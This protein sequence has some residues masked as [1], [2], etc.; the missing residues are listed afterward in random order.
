MRTRLMRTSLL[1]PILLALLFVA[2]GSAFGQ[3]NPDAVYQIRARHSRMCLDV[4]GGS[5]SN[6]AQVIQ[7]DCHGGD[8]QK[9]TF[10]PVGGGYYHIN[11]K[12]SGKSLDV[13]G[14]IGAQGDNVM[15]DQWDYVGADNQLWR[16]DHVGE[17][18]YIVAKHS[19][20]RLGIR[21][22]WIYTN[23]APARQSSN[24]DISS[25]QWQ[26]IA[27]TPCP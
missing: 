22:V 12:H 20:L 11:A 21:G 13:F 23:G 2:A 9:W 10:T 16:L 1:T 17:F 5:L 15:V 24:F 3:I 27:L 19:G 18:Y 14:G 8:N 26:L 7:W 4:S 25:Q 6:R